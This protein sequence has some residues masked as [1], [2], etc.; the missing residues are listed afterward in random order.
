MA[1]VLGKRQLCTTLDFRK[2]FR[3]IQG[4][5][6]FNLFDRYN[7]IETI[8]N[9]YIDGKYK[10][11]LAHP[12][13]N[14]EDII[15][16][17]IPYKETPQ[18]LNVLTSDKYQKYE[19]TKIETLSHYKGVIE[20]LRQAGKFAEAEHLEKAI[21]YVD[22]Q[23]VFCFDEK[24]VLGVWGMHIRDRVVISNGIFTLDM[25]VSNPLPEQEQPTPIIETPRPVPPIAYTVS[26]FSNEGG[27][28]A[29]NHRV[30]KYENEGLFEEDIPNVIPNPGYTFTGWDKQP[31]NHIV[32]SDTDFHAQF[33]KDV[34]LPPEVPWYRRGCLRWLLWFLLLLLVLFL[35][36]WLLRGCFGVNANPIPYPIGEKPFIHE[37]PRSG[38]GGMYNPGDPYQGLPT[39]P[40]YKDILPPFQGM[41][42][43]IDTSQ[44]VREP[45]GPAI[46]GNRLNILM[47]N[48][49]KS[50]M[51][52]AKEFK[53]KYPDERFK[54]V[55]Y[56]DVVKRMQVEIPIEEKSKLKAEIPTAFS[57]KYE[58]FVFDEALFESLYA[59]NDEA[60]ND[61][62]KS[63]YLNAIGAPKAWNITR[64][65]KK[66]TVAIV[67][68]GFNLKHPELKDKIVMPYNVWQKDKMVYAHREDHGTHV[69]GIALAKMDNNKGICGIAPE[70]A[71]MPVQVSDKQGLMTITSVLDGILYALYQGADVINVSLGMAFQGIDEQRQRE[72]QQNYF[73]EEERLW[74]EVMKIADNHKAIIVVAAGNENILAGVNPMN[75][76]KHFV[77]VSAVDK[78]RDPYKKATFSNFGDYSTVSAPGVKIYSTIGESGYGQMDGTSMSAPVVAGSIALMKSINENLNSEQ[79]ICLLQQTGISLPDE[80]GNVIQLDK[81][82]ERVK[83]GSFPECK[84]QPKTPSTGDVQILLSWDNYN[85]LDLACTDPS[86]NT[87]WY[88]NVKVSSGGMLEID[89]NREP[90][91]SRTPIENIF[92]PQ[93]KAPMGKYKVF[94]SL[95][96]QHDQSINENPYKVVLKYGDK[97]EE[98]SGTIKREEKK[99]MIH[100]KT[101]ILGNSDESPSS[102]PS[103]SQIRKEDAYGHYRTKVLW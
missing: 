44:L 15:W 66:L 29:G 6:N 75:R 80:I 23:F 4:Y 41:L 3:S 98:F 79:I 11:F 13:L 70:C 16:F 35:L 84:S 94:V 27:S 1:K 90:N 47:E 61:P 36:F 91:D 63:W 40:A 42:P 10:H 64:G 102:D 48:T 68:N 19:A 54:V 65:N 100:I 58:L 71:F 85:D 26:F 24:V 89:K 62:D 101:F 14:R 7:T 21:K 88:E 34:S 60:F 82:L 57:N 92:W 9:K 99:K 17:T 103:A 55:Y 77:I 32:H 76:P 5:E 22:D 96:E 86:G 51:D 45:G 73:K 30:F 2:H 78:N 69:A 95:Y 46:L 33:V 12:I 83:S 81:V 93:G 97:K 49:D 8:V 20:S 59:P 74:K 31:L 53:A 25:E 28:L 72:L 67:D 50:I 38:S 39:P 43:P 56:D 87:V 52:L 18:Q 37:D